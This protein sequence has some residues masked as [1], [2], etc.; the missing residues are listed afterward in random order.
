MVSDRGSSWEQSSLLGSEARVAIG[1]VGKGLQKRENHLLRD[2]N[3][4]GRAHTQ[5]F[6]G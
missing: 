4:R 5:S 3:A 1:W 6:K 2:R